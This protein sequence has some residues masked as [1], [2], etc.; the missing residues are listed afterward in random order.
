[1]RILQYSPLPTLSCDHLA[2]KE[3]NT[4]ATSDVDVSARRI[5]CQ[6][7]RDFISGRITNDEFEKRFPDTRDGAVGAIWDTSWVFCDDFKAHRLDGK[8]R[9]SLNERR[10][11]MRWLLFLH[12]KLPYEWPDLNLP[13]LDPAPRMQSS[14][15]RRLF[16]QHQNLSEPEVKRFLSSGHFPVWPFTRVSDYKRALA[17]PKFFAGGGPSIRPHP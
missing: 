6:V 12:G 11:C 8:H 15:W 2:R 16:S 3:C 1:M 9:L 13:G 10:V 14:F 7:L 17:S 4:M 5:A